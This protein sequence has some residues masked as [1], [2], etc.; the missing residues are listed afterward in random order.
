MVEVL[1]YFG[2]V[3]YNGEYSVRNGVTNTR[4]EH[5]DSFSRQAEPI[6]EHHKLIPVEKS[7]TGWRYEA[8]FSNKFVADPLQKSAPGECSTHVNTVDVR[9]GAPA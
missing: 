2:G 8:K 1:V 9:L 4:E 7:E 5:P 6:S 3:L